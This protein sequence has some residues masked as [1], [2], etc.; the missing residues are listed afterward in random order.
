[1]RRKSSNKRFFESKLDLMIS[2]KTITSANESNS[3]IKTGKKSKNKGKVTNH[4]TNLYK[5]LA[6]KNIKTDDFELNKW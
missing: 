1:M 6:I 2:K 5:I 3:V 4:F